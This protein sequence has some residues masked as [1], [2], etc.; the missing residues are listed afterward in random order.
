MS[1]SRTKTILIT[2]CSE[3]GIGA[4]LA[5]RL[6]D[7]GHR[8]FATARDTLKIPSKVREHSNVTTLALDVADDGSVMAAS[9]AF[10]AAASS[11]LDVLVNNAGAGYTMPLLDVDIDKAKQ[12][13]D[14]NV[15]GPLRTVQVF[16]DLLMETRGR[17]VNI[18]SATGC[19]YSPWVGAYSSSKSALHTVSETLRMELQPFGVTVACLITG[20][21]ATRFHT[22]EGEFSLPEKSLYADIL[23]TISLWARG[24][25]GPERGTVDD[26]VTQILPD[27]LSNS[28]G[29][30]LWRGAN[31]GAVRFAV[32]WL[33]YYVLDKL[34]VLNQGLEQL[35]QSI[36]EKKAQ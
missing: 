10:R 21:V 22:N 12:C 23:S 15:W 17:V 24:A 32:S 20:T 34:V 16:A 36:L 7:Q 8:V 2:G 5:L 28:R 26:Y 1:A 25:T 4:A 30:V 19:L 27:V 14:V 11:G 9:A 6:A 18:G 13:H 3:D 35:T 29:G 31:A 33:P